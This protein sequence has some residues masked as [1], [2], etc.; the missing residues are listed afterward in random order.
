MSYSEPKSFNPHE[1]GPE[2]RAMLRAAQSDGRVVASLTDDGPSAGNGLA[3]YAILET[4]CSKGLLAYDGD[5]GTSDELEL[6][7]VLT[8]A[9]QT[10]LSENSL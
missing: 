1:F 5:E 4:L 6:G 7:F 10:F 2:E 9:G 3:R 8:D